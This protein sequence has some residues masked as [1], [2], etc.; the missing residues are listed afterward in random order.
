[1]EATSSFSF[2]LSEDHQAI[3]A[4]IRE[5][6]ENEIKPHVAELDET[7]TFPKEIFTKLGNLGFLGVVIPTEY[8]GSG[9]GYV[10]YAII[11]EEVARVCPS[12]EIGRAH[13]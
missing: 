10:E 8:N 2:E 12:I 3:R 1:M 4:A 11:V 13:V 7:Q 5:F 9:L 6:A